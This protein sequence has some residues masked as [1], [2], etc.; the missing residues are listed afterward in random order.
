MANKTA[1]DYENDYRTKETA[2][3][4][5]SYDTRKANTEQ[6]KTD[7]T[8]ST[9]TYLKGQNEIIES[10]LDNSTKKVQQQIDAAPGEYQRLFDRNALS[11]EVGRHA[12]EVKMANMGMSDSGLNRSTQAALS[13]QRM[14]AD[15]AARKSMREYVNELENQITDMTVEA[16]N[17]K[18]QIG[19]DANYKDQQD[20][21]SW[22]A[23]DDTWYRD[24]LDNIDTNAITYGANMWQ[25][26]EANRATVE[27]AQIEAAATQAKAQQDGQQA[28]FDNIIKLMDK[29]GM[30]YDQ[31]ALNYEAMTG[32]G[33]QATYARN[34]LAAIKAGYSDAEAAI[35]ANAGG[36]T[37]G[38]IAVAN[39]RIGA[40]NVNVNSLTKAYGGGNRGIFG[41]GWTSRDKDLEHAKG[42][43]WTQENWDKSIARAVN[44]ATSN[45]KKSGLD[46]S[47]K[48]IAAAIAVGST[49]A[50]AATEKTKTKMYNALA[51]KFSGA[52]LEA[53]CQAAG[54]VAE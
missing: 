46:D 50:E 9:Q 36:G 41:D 17:Q 12:A 44:E 37:A 13:A 20:F 18:K 26:D 30:S 54:I 51:S 8:A 52:A 39:Q 7:R 16:E 33:E 23:A 27:A 32:S 35:Y 21:Q 53:A 31:A 49:Y 40:A 10:A 48:M 22:D 45:L 42:G 29:G 6:R 19:L 38:E 5:N 1:T 11:E 15:A 14:N 25:A 3:A 2:N 28:Y 47:S 34:Y 4:Q 24:R 43:G